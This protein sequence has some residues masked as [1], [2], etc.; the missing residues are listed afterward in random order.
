MIWAASFHVSYN[1]YWHD[2]GIFWVYIIFNFAVVFFSTWCFLEG[3]RAVVRLFK[4]QK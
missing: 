1:H 3:W 4:R 2:F